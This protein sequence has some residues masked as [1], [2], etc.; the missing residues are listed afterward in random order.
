[1]LQDSQGLHVACRPTSASEWEA[2][3]EDLRRNFFCLFPFVGMGREFGRDVIA[4]ELR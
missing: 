3:E 4:D 2:M 1:M